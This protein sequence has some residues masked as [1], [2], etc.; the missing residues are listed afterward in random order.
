MSAG[1]PEIL[2]DQTKHDICLAI[3]LGCSQRRAAQFVGIDESTIRKAADRDPQFRA[4][5]DR[6]AVKLEMDCLQRIASGEKSWRSSAWLIENVCSPRPGKK[7]L[8]PHKLRL[9]ELLDKMPPLPHLDDSPFLPE[10]D[11]DSDPLTSP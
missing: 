4:Q 6:A 1:R 8:E 11:E 7:T 3:S 9:L 10:P 2:N 5:L